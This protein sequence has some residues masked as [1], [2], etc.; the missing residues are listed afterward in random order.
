MDAERI[1]YIL[2][3]CAMIAYLRREIGAD[4]VQNIIVNSA[5]VCFAHAINLCEVYYDFWRV[6][7]R[8]RR[9]PSFPYAEDSH[10]CRSGMFSVTCT[11]FSCHCIW[12]RKVF[13]S[14]LSPI[15]SGAFDR[16]TH[17]VRDYSAMGYIDGSR[18]DCCLDCFPDAD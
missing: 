18:I 11:R 13:P 1:I 10:S 14:I 3:S 17:I 8:G 15:C 9:L 6:G 12:K 7:G 2:D 5:S 16:D 4:V